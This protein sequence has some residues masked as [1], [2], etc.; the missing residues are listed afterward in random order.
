[1]DRRDRAGG[2]GRYTRYVGHDFAAKKLVCLLSLSDVAVWPFHWLL[3]MKGALPE[4]LFGKKQYPRTH[5]WIERFSAA[6]AKAK[7]SVPKATTLEGNE[8]VQRI[9]QAGFAEAEGD[10]DE[11]DPLRLKKGQE[12]EVWPTDTGF[13][14]RDRGQLVSLTKDEVVIAA[15]T[16]VGETEVRIHAPRAGFGIQAVRENDAKL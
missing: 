2:A 10:V 1:M 11:E 14:H 13:G 5:A 3:D 8:A 16:K 12:V 4:Q 15:K 9:A 6:I 7:A